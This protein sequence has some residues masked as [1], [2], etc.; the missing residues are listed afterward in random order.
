[1]QL[2]NEKDALVRKSEYLNVLEQLADVEHE[3]ADLQKKL[4]QTSS[5]EGPSFPSLFLLS[6][7]FS[8]K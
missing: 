1:M 6:E 7:K 8:Y 5:S 3:I 2:L 4:G